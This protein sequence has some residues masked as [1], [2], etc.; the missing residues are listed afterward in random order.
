MVLENQPYPRDVRVRA[1]AEALAR[2]GHRVTVLAPRAPGQARTEEVAGVQVRRFRSIEARR[3]AAGFMVEYAIAHVQ[4]LRMAALELAR[5]ADVLHL[6]NPPDT[7]FVAG[8]L[9]RAVGRR[10][11]FDQHDLFPEVLESR[12]RRSPLVAVALAAQRAALRTATVVLVTNESQREVAVAR[13]GI[14][15]AAIAVV[16]NGPPR[17]TLVDEVAV[18]PGA[19]A[20]PRLVYVGELG[21]QDG[22]LDLPDLL[23]RP[24]LAEARLTIVGDGA[25]RP[26]LE[27]AVAARPALAGRVTFAGRVAHAD[28]PAVLAQADVGIDP[29]PG[30]PLNQRSTMI[31]IAEYLAAGL[32]VVAY[33]LVETRRTAGDAALYAPAD[34]AAAF[35][36]HV[37]ELAADPMLRLALARRGRARAEELVWERS[38]RV[39]LTAYDRLAACAL[40]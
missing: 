8:L 38:E 10:V 13:G 1:E 28:V 3:R 4:L 22:V 2:A 20:H 35:T 9:A 31:K 29:A 11:V 37:S 19:L 23:D 16:R 34:D 33:D 32:P 14:P 18:R 17:A 12:F 5:G 36:A 39:L 26:E 40:R 25:V 6:H 15:A 24:A 7:L 21:P 27:A 30:T